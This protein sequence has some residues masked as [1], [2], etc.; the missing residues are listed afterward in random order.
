MSGSAKAVQ[1]SSVG[2]TFISVKKRFLLS[3]IVT[4]VHFASAHVAEKLE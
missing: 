2:D 3:P 4:T 1:E